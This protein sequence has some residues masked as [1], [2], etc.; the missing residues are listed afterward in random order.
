ML[1]GLKTSILFHILFII[2]GEL[3]LVEGAFR[4]LRRVELPRGLSSFGSRKFWDLNCFVLDHK[5]IDNLMMRNEEQ[6][7]GRS[8]YGYLNKFN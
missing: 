7:K 8:N 6:S 5:E 3:P 4:N 2:L 1:E